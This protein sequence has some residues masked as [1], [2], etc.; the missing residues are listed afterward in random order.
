MG[1]LF[2]RGIPDTIKHIIMIGLG[3]FTCVFGVKMGLEM[4][5]PLVVVL[6]IVV[7]GAVGQV[8]RIE[9][10]I[11]TMGDRLRKLI[12][13]R[14]QS[15]FAQGFVFASLLFCVGPMTIL[16]CIKAG[17]EGDPELLF[18]KSIMD[19]VSAVIL[20]STLGLGVLLSALTVLILQG[21]LVLLSQQLTFLTQPTYL[22][23]FTGVGGI[24]IL[25]IGIKLLGVKQLKAGNFLP[26]LVFVILFTFLS[27]FIRH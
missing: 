8:I 22:G 18:I 5:Q 17:I 1:L 26:A 19:G 21:V 3:L 9:E 2:K 24:I 11:E 4:Q 12:G 20:A 7:G 15:S 14:D 13:S 16:G 6:S 27:T 25:G 23:D 10:G